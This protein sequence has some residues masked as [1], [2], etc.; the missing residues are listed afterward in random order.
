MSKKLYVGNLKFDMTDQELEE[1]FAPYGE[2]ISATIVVDR[3]SGRSKGFGF[4]EFA[5]DEDADEARNALNGKELKG[6]T[7]RIDN[8]RD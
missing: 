1:A 5:K 6:R 3:I 7:V 4:V 8:A 2:I